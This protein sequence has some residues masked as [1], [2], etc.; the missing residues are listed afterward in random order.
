[1]PQ[2]KTIVTGHGKFASGFQG[3]I[4]LLAG[5][6][7]N[8]KFI[9]FEDGMSEVDL[10]EKFLKSMDDEPTLF[11]TDLTGGTPY[12]EAAKIAYESSNILVVAGCNLASLL[13]TTF[14]NYKSLKD[15]ANDLVSITKQSAELFEIDTD[16]DDS[17]PENFDDGI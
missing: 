12:K 1:M 14:N 6:Q 9:D 15:Y 16:E 8:M 10:R 11:F 2:Y 4:K 17:T 5:K 3:A 7:L 13:E